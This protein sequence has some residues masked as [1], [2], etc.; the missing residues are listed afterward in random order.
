[1]HLVGLHYKNVCDLSQD[2]RH[3]TNA[4]SLAELGGKTS[5][6]VQFINTNLNNLN[7]YTVRRR[8]CILCEIIPGVQL[9]SGPILI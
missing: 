1:V 6:T 3:V 4:V 9:K 5:K 2:T 7:L 8:V